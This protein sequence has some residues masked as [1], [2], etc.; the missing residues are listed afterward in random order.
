[1]KTAPKIGGEVIKEQKK[2]VELV[3]VLV[4]VLVVLVFKVTKPILIVAQ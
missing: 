2:V 3:V 1:M 4:V